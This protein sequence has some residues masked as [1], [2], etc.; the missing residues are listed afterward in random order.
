[1]WLLELH[2]W[3][4][5][6]NT[7]S[8]V[9]CRE[10]AMQNKLARNP[11]IINTCNCWLKPLFKKTIS[12]IFLLPEALKGLWLKLLS[13]AGGKFSSCY[14]FLSFHLASFWN[15]SK[16]HGLPHS[17]F[18]DFMSPYFSVFFF[19]FLTV[20]T[21]HNYYY[22]SAGVKFK[23]ILQLLPL[24]VIFSSPVHCPAW[25]LWFFV[26]LQK[27]MFCRLFLLLKCSSSL[28]IGSIWFHYRPLR[29]GFSPLIP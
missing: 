26:V 21:K 2:F 6:R 13:F 8:I 3:D 9:I 10:A 20:R 24:V 19:P 28:P 14:Y 27:H 12:F 5:G 17:W 23:A 29:A 1:M 16:L 11:Y 7:I 4:T 22:H 15:S 18:L 25:P